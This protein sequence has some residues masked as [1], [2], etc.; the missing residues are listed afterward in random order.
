VAIDS[1]AAHAGQRSLRVSFSSSAQIDFKSVSQLVVAEPAT[2]YRLTFFVR[3]E[4]LKSAATIYTEVLDGTGNGA[5]LGSS[6][7]VAVGTQD[8]QP[9][10]IEFTTGPRTESVLVR[11]SRAGCA[12]GV[13]PIFGK[14]WY[15]DFDLQRAANRA[16]AR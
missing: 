4:E 2:R 5:A 9:V 3:A 1:R 16:P 8:W 11:L 6:P 7:P 13:C 15:D 12:D 10:T 14:I